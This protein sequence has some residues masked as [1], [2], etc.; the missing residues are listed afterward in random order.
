[1]IRSTARCACRTSAPLPARTSR[2]LPWT[3]LGGMNPPLIPAEPA[4]SNYA[5]CQN[6]VEAPIDV[7]NH[8]GFYLNSRVRRG[9]CG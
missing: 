3:L 8:G 5:A 2:P 6:D 7:D 9:G 1:M 4:R